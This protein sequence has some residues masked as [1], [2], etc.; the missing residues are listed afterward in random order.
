MGGAR[1]GRSVGGTR[2][3]V[4]PLLPIVGVGTN[5]GRI[6]DELRTRWTQQLVPRHPSRSLA[7]GEVLGWTTPTAGQIG[8]LEPVPASADNSEGLRSLITK[9]GI[10]SGMTVQ[11]IGDDDDV[12]DTFR[13]AVEA[14]TGSA[15]VGLEFEEVVDAVLLWH[16]EDDDDL[17]DALVDAV[18]QLVESGPIIL[19]T[20]KPGRS[21]H[22]EPAEI[23]DAAPTAGLQV[24][25]T[26]SAGPDW[27]GTRMVTPKG[28]RR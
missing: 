10:A 6:A 11:E 3:A 22:I 15:I 14:V 8:R 12:D 9:L 4:A 7:K 19:L 27:Q 23:A 20:P 17:V 1:R 26:V 18:V 24:T 21:G 28:P 16:R 5:R 13:A 25:T 2:P